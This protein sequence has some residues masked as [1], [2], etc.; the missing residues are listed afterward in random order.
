MQKLN[1][2]IDI[3]NSAAKVALVEQAKVVEIYRFESNFIENI[4][5]I[6]NPQIASA[7]ISSTRHRDVQLIDFIKSRVPHTVVFSHLTPT[8]LINRY[9]TIET[10][11]M[12]RL[13]AAVGAWSLQPGTDLL[14]VDFGTAITID[15]V[16]SGGEYFGG[17]I[18]PGMAMRFAAL[19]HFTDRLPLVVYD[20]CLRGSEKFGTTTTQAIRNGVIC[21]IEYEI[22]GYIKENTQAKIFF[23]GSDAINFVKSSK[24]AIFADYELVIKGLDRILEYDVDK[25]DTKT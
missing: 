9:A 16:T 18:S 10:L 25:Y 17:N 7:I 3:G 22:E 4:E 11:G 12:D 24:S 1:L 21:G 13:A 15:K 6:L 23:T 14:I 8:P 5:V 2:I 20:E 19:N